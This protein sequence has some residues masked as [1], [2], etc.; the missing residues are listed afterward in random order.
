MTTQTT[1]HLRTGGLWDNLEDDQDFIN[2]RKFTVENSKGEGMLT[3]EL[4]SDGTGIRICGGHLHEING[5]NHSGVLSITPR[6]L[7]EIEVR[8]CLTDL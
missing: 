8:T 2:G 3:I 5:N 7:G 1:L 6:A 4:L